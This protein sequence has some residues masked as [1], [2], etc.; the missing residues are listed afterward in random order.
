[1]SGL[2][3]WNKHFLWK[4]TDRIKMWTPFPLQHLL[5]KVIQ[6]EKR[7]KLLQMLDQTEETRLHFEK[8]RRWM[9]RKGNQGERVPAQQNR[10]DK[11][12]I[13]GFVAR[14]R[15]WLWRLLR[16][17]RKYCRCPH[18]TCWLATGQRHYLVL[19]GSFLEVLGKKLTNAFR[20]TI[21]NQYI[22]IYILEKNFGFTKTIVRITLKN[23]DCRKLAW[24]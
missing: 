21:S 15:I 13:P 17:V 12:R 1:M 23:G 5:H 6:C 8:Q 7:D 14:N 18:W 3:R 19:V 2:F 11:G 10:Q 16:I 4:K 22:Y 24:K 20:N 9:V